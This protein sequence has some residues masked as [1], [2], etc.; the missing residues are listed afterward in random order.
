VTELDGLPVVRPEMVVLHLYATVRPER[1]ERIADTLWS[2]RCFSG[3][4]L[5][6]LLDELGARGRNGVAGLRS[7]LDERGEGYVPPASGL[8]S[9]AQQILHQVGIELRRQV[10]TG[11]ELWSGRVDFRHPTLPLVV[12]VN[13]E[14]YHRALSD[15]RHDSARRDRLIADGFV[16][17]ELTDLMVWTRPAE[18]VLRVRAGIRAA[19][20][21]VETHPASSVLQEVS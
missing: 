11:G 14:R 3:S 7:Y 12:E 1:A 9:R 17:V 2:M 15:V 16:V 6:A 8:E 20:T 5:R 21:A 19:R 4:S 10:D 18:V 13:S